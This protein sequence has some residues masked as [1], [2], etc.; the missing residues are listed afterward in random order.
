MKLFLQIVCF[1]IFS[2]PIWSFIFTKG[3][4]FAAKKKMIL[5]SFIGPV[6]GTVG[7]YLLGRMH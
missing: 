5:L 2:L 6:L 1:A 3:Q 7:L 4:T